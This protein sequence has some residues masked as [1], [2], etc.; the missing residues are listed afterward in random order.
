ME[1]HHRDKRF[2]PIGERAANWPGPRRAHARSALFTDPV[3]PR[4]SSPTAD[5]IA[6]TIPADAGSTGRWGTAVMR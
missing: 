1:P 2:A 6:I 4:R 5:A 3:P